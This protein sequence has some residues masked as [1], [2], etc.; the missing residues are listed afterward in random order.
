VTALYEIVPVGARGLVDPLRYSAPAD[1]AAA[2]SS[3]LAHVRLRYKKPDSNRSELLEYPILESS[4]LA[5][6]QLSADFR[7]AA[8]VAA[9]GQILRGGKYTGGFRYDDVVALAQ[10]ALGE[11]REGYRRELISLVKL[12]QGLTADADAANRVSETTEPS[13]SIPIADA[14]REQP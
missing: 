12:A 11:D 10:G 6:A 2:R 7:F 4:A 14:Q 8:G 13:Q 3:E 1:T 5:A 9:F